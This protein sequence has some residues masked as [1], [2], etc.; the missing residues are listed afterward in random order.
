MQSCH[1]ASTA[2]HS[3]LLWLQAAIFISKGRN[4]A[5]TGVSLSRELNLNFDK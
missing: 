3:A 1:G 4:A 2:K 5:T